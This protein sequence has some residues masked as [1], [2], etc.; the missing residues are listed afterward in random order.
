VN[1]AV[2]YPA[3]GRTLIKASL[4]CSEDGAKEFDAIGEIC[5]E[6]S[7]PWVMLSGGAAH[8]K[9]ERV[10]EYAYAAGAG[11]FLAGRTIWLDAVRSHFPD[12]A[13]VSLALK[14]QSVT[15]LNSLSAVTKA[16]A[17][18]WQPVFPKFDHVHQEGDFARA[19]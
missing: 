7:I 5:D 11:G 13:A 18:S 4:L 15:I 16:R 19:Y 3:L 12:L 9:F 2:G 17:P 14:K 8:D 6:C 10:L 1:R